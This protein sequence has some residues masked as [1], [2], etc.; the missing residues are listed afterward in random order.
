M[1][2]SFFVALALFITVCP[3]IEAMTP[4]QEALRQL[5][6]QLEAGGTLEINGARIAA[7]RLIPRLYERLGFELAWTN[8]EMVEQLLAGV[9]G[10][11]SH[12]LDPADYHQAILDKRIAGGAWRSANAQ[13]SVEL[14]LLLTDALARL[15]FTLHYGKLDPKQLDPVWN[16][17]RDFDVEDPAGIFALVLQSGRIKLFLDEAQ[18]Q[19]PLYDRIR[20]ALQRCRDIESGGGWS[21]VSFGPILKRGDRGARV[22]ELARRL[23]ASGDL[24][25][26]NGEPFDVYSEQ[27]ENAVRR[28]QSRHGI[29]PDGKVGPRTLEEL[30]VPVA[31]RIDQLRT[32]LERTRWVF[33]DIEDHYLVVNIAGFRLNLFQHG[34]LIWTTPVQVGKPYHATPIFKSTMRYLVFN[35]TWTVPPG[36]LKNETLPDIR[37]DTGYLAKQNM[38]VVTSSGKIVDP[39]TVDWIGPFPYFLRQEPGPKNALGRVKF[40]F[41]NEYMVY[42]HDTPSKGLFARAERASSHGCIRVQD[43][44]TL[45]ELLLEGTAGWDRSAIDRTVESGMTT[46][47]FLA[48]PL[49]VMLLYWTAMADEAGTVIFYKDV[50]NRDAAIIEGLNSPFEFT[51]PSGL[52]E[53]FRP[54]PAPLTS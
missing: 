19:G 48:E 39:A 14:D 22:P 43:P 42:L 29:D 1:I 23:T 41:P 36:I 13:A 12:G 28:F 30:N 26:E 37:K 18:P 50:Y 44:L 27:I 51:Q 35:P 53:A 40:I 52:S 45:A 4:E 54:Q 10:A 38:S 17:S 46:T 15:A 24:V 8:P 47:V 3:I 32:N 34:D 31:A 11:S 25:T 33:R 2:R 16:L 9:R 21:I 6:E 5:T 7:R 20:E 49:T